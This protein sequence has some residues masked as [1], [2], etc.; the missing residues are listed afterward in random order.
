M[1]RVF[2]IYFMVGA[3]VGLLLACSD[4]DD[5][6]M[7]RKHTSVDALFTTVMVALPGGGEEPV[8][9]QVNAPD[10]GWENSSATMPRLQSLAWRS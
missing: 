7:N 2:A 10:T 6:E 3:L 1:H 5:N 9:V 4:D 8:T